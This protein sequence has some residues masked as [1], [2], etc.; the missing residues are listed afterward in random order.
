MEEK[1]T[2]SGINYLNYQRKSDQSNY[3]KQTKSDV[4]MAIALA[5]SYPEFI[6]ILEN[7][8]YE[9]TERANKL[10][11]RDLEY[12][13]NIRI[14]RRFGEDYTID[15]IKKQILGLYLPEKKTYYRNYFQRDSV[16]DNLFKMISDK[17]DEIEKNQE[18]K[19]NSEFSYK[20]EELKKSQIDQINNSIKIKEPN[21]MYQLN[22]LNS[23]VI[24]Y[25]FL[26]DIF[27]EKCVNIKDKD[28]YNILKNISYN[29]IS[30]YNIMADIL[31]KL[32]NYFEIMNAEIINLKNEN[33]KKNKYISQINDKILSYK[34]Q[35]NKNQQDNEIISIKLFDNKINNQQINQL[36]DKRRKLYSKI[37]PKNKSINNF[38]YARDI[39]NKKNINNKIIQ[40]KK[41]LYKNSSEIIINNQNNYFSDISNLFLIGNRI[42]TM[43]MIKDIINN[44][45]S[46]KNNFNNKCI[47]NKLPKETMEEY[48]YTYLNHKYG[49]KNM[50][51]E[52]ATNIINGIKNYSQIDNEICLFGKILRNDLDESCQFIMPK[53]KKK[54]EDSI[55]KVLKKE[56][57]FKGDEEINEYKN[58]LIKNR[59]PL[60][61]VQMILNSIYNRSEIEKIIPKITE[62]V[63][64]YK[65]KVA[66]NELNDKDNNIL[67]G[68]SCL[69]NKD[70]PC[71]DKLS[72]IEL[73]QKLIEKENESSSIEYNELTNIC[74]ELEVDTRENYLKPFIDIF[75]LIDE[76]NDGILNEN[77]FIN[78]IKAL[79]IYNEN[80]LGNEINAILNLIDPYGYKKFIFS[81]C[82]QVL[83]NYNINIYISEYNN[84]NIINEQNFLLLNI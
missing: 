79:K 49:L 83:S 54:L 71:H 82:V 53:I 8:N 63:N 19:Y 33:N 3:S 4:D 26:N 10:S 31:V 38:E 7:M 42:L 15:N 59:L 61:L 1:K 35:L 70:N 55:I 77:Q 66:N 65:I 58:K 16:I 78:L 44:I 17:L 43:K 46:S 22:L 72:R 45:Y 18:Q 67:Y 47:E 75:K 56:C 2:K 21:Y 48:M 76:D 69:N 34:E 60:N 23:R 57:E 14:E 74:H 81:D 40:N 41:V 5:T 64:E 80:N 20:F 30:N 24:L 28:E 62:K 6:T 13:R 27:L 9:V 39:N 36:N 11:V 32:L 84:K 25:N 12:N 73:K 68:L 52:W 51:I 50:V 29:I 37:E